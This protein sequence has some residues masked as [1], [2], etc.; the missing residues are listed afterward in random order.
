MIV[1]QY[2]PKAP[3]PVVDSIWELIA[4]PGDGQRMHPVPPLGMPELIFFIGQ[5]SPFQGVNAQRCIVKGQY[6]Q[7]QKVT[8]RF[9]FHL[10]IIRLKPYG[11]HQLLGMNASTLTDTV[12][13]GEAFE[14]MRAMA[15]IFTQQ[16]TMEKALQSVL[17]LLHAY[18]HHAVSSE[19]LRFLELLEQS[20]SQKVE[21]VIHQQ[22]IGLRNLQRSFVREVG[23]SPK[24]YLRMMRMLQLHRALPPEPDWMQ[25]VSEYAFSDQS[26]FVKEFK[27]IM[28]HTPAQ[29][30]REHLSLRE[31]LPPFEGREI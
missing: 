16:P 5:T 7:L 13:D 12:A 25:L 29:F 21:Q 8:F 1:R 4:D 30:V 14:V 2:L 24:K 9:D 23:L 22:G 15:D 19:T 11:L 18:P 17:T 26:H 6:T 31:I 10:I 20:S 3:S 28:Q 27:Q